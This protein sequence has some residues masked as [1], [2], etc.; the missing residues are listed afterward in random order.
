MG[1]R[2]TKRFTKKQIRAVFAGSWVSNENVF[3]ELRGMKNHLVGVFREAF[4]KN[5]L[6]FLDLKTEREQ[7]RLHPSPWELS[8][9][10]GLSVARSSHFF[11]NKPEIWILM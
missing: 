2:G 8:E 1:R 7:S 9:E 4:V 3:Q 11:Q 5:W 6:L 10:M